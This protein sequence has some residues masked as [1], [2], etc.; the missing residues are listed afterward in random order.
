ML[1]NAFEDAADLS[2]TEL[3][4]AYERE[5]AETIETEGLDA[6][7]AASDIDRKTLSA[8]VDGESPALTLDEAAAILAADTDRSDADAIAAEARDILLIGMTNAVLDVERLASD[9][10]GA[11][12]PKELQQKLEGRAPL[13]LREYALVHGYLAGA[14]D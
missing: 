12:E 14:T 13:M 3:R 9:L 1:R 7:A 5:L 4:S 2:P 8:L 10:D 6:V 11:F